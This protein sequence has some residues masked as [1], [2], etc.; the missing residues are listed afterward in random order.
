MKPNTLLILV[1]AAGA[2]AAQ[3][4]KHED[5]GEGLKLSLDGPGAKASASAGGGDIDTST[6]IPGGV[7]GGGAAGLLPN[8]LPADFLRSVPPSGAGGGHRESTVYLMHNGKSV[9]VTRRP[10]RYGGEEVVVTTNDGGKD[11]VEEMSLPEYERRYLGKKAVK[12]KAR[13][14]EKNQGRDKEKAAA[15]GT[16]EERRA[17][18]GAASSG[19]AEASAAGSSTAESGSSDTKETD[20]KADASGASENGPAPSAPERTPDPAPAGGGLP[21]TPNRATE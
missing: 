13:G 14:Q 19:S 15:Q 7:S 11:K 6:W 17:G 16:V 21:I 4:I 1:L 9:K 3:D 12:E 2:A 20:A 18:G 8:G 5:N 10:S